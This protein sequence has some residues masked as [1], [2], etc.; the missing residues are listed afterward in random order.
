[1]Q[2]QARQ[3]S[4]KEQS[5]ALNQ[6]S[7]APKKQGAFVKQEPWGA[8][9]PKKIVQKP[10]SIT[11]SKKALEFY[12]KIPEPVMKMLMSEPEAANPVVQLKWKVLGPLNIYELEAKNPGSFV[13][14]KTLELKFGRSLDC[15]FLEG[16]LDT[17]RK[18]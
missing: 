9:S 3:R 8:Q 1:M 4:L 16:Q 5:E 2:P 6:E 18:V 12:T 13:T 11:S 10:V 14:Q 15:D 7:I 17:E